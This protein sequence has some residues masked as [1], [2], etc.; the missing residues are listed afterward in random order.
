M[1]GGPAVLVTGAAGYVGRLCVAALAKRS[2]APD[3]SASVP[4]P[5]S[6]PLVKVTGVTATSVA[7]PMNHSRYLSARTAVGG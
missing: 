2:A 1:A 4:A 3:S 7:A 5:G 6:G